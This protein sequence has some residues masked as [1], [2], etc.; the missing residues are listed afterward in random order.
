MDNILSIICTSM[1][2]LGYLKCRLMQLRARQERPTSASTVTD[3][4]FQIEDSELYQ[5]TTELNR[6]RTR[7][8][9]KLFV[10]LIFVII[11]SCRLIVCRLHENMQYCKAE[12]QIFPV[13]VAGISPKGE[14]L[15]CP[16][17][18]NPH[19]SDISGDSYE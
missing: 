6:W 3:G 13:F 12:L 17:S 19:D 4:N 8:E 1:F 9:R 15:P 5:R 10:K 11:K 16:F 14:T 18:H 7:A 2:Q